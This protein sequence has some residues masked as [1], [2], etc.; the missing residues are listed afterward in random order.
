MIWYFPPP[1]ITYA[2]PP[3]SAQVFADIEQHASF[4]SLAQT[5]V[6][7]VKHDH[8]TVLSG[9]I[10]QASEKGLRKKGHISSIQ[11]TAK[12]YFWAFLQQLLVSSRSCSESQ[13]VGNTQATLKQM[14]QMKCCYLSAERSIPLQR[15][16]DSITHS[17]NAP[18]LLLD[19][20]T[21]YDATILDDWKDCIYCI[22]VSQSIITSEDITVIQSCVDHDG[23][24]SREVCSVQHVCQV[25]QCNIFI[26]PEREERRSCQCDV[27]K[28]AF[29][30]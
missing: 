30:L 17:E 24:I 23:C 25:Y 14:P 1:L 29:P 16:L 19:R 26:V 9:C 21:Q 22:Y 27:I 11:R 8:N 5:L 15:Q 7:P 20:T 3:V 2:G 12:Y 6:W 28:C 13:I 10:P 4:L 18:V